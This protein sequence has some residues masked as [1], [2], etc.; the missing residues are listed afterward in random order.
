MQKLENY[1]FEIGKLKYNPSLQ[2]VRWVGWFMFLRPAK[3]GIKPA[4]DLRPI[5]V[6]TIV[7]IASVI[8]MGAFA[9]VVPT[10]FVKP[11]LAVGVLA[12]P[13]FCMFLMFLCFGNK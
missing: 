9:L 6:V 1:E 13:A 2:F 12:V 4:S 5:W 11:V 7:A 8:L 3:A 10:E